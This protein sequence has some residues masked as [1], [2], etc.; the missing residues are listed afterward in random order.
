VIHAPAPSPSS[1][2][3]PAFHPCPWGRHQLD[4]FDRTRMS[5]SRVEIKVGPAGPMAEPALH[6]A[7]PRDTRFQAFTTSPEPLDQ[8][9]KTTSSRSL[10]A[11]NQGKAR[12]R[13]FP[14]TFRVGRRV[15]RGVRR[16]LNQGSSA[17]FWEIRRR[18]RSAS[19]APSN[20]FLNASLKP[21]EKVSSPGSSLVSAR[22]IVPWWSGLL[23][24]FWAI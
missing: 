9:A 5:G 12:A 2:E 11:G 13:R 3:Q 14:Y 16:P 22:R 19:K 15:P 20:G 24:R 23:R 4:G 6:R 10:L 17:F 8:E 1:S 21:S 18:T 7:C